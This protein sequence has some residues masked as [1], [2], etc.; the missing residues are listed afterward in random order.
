M[1]SI[2]IV[3]ASVLCLYIFITPL[4]AKSGENTYVF[5]VS[6]CPPWKTKMLEKHAKDIAY[7]CKNDVDIFTSSVQDALNVPSENIYRLVDEQ[8]TY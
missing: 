3:A 1:R 6:A 7:A 4:W 2:T 8:A 5:A